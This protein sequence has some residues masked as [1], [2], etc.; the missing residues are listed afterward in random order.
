MK[1]EVPVDQVGS[2]GWDHFDPVVSAL[3][4][5]LTSASPPSSPWPLESSVS[6]QLPTYPSLESPCQT[7]LWSVLPSSSACAERAMDNCHLLLSLPL[8]KL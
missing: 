2:K 5:I 8:S 3:T 4:S 1:V 6:D 7:F